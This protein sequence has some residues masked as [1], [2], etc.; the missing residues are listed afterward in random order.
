MITPLPMLLVIL[1]TVSHMAMGDKSM[2][3]YC[4]K[5]PNFGMGSY[6]KESNQCNVKYAIPTTNQ[7]EAQEFCEMQHPYSL[8]QVTH[9]KETWCYIMAELECGSSE[10]LIGENCFL[11]DADSKHSEGDD[12]CRAHGRT[13]KMHRITSVFEQKWLATF[14]SAYG[15]MWVKNAE[16]ENRHLLVTEVKDKIMINKEGRLAIGTSPNYVIVTRKGAVAGIKPGRLVRMNPNVEMPLLCSRPATPRK[17]YLKSIG[18][19]ME[20]IGYKITVARDLGDIDRPF[21]VIRGLH[22]FVMKDEY[23]AG[24]EDLYDSCSAFQHGYPATPYDFKNPEDFKKVLRE[25]E[26]NIVA[27]PGQKHTASQTP[28]MEKCTKDSDFERQRTHFYFNIKRKDGSFFEKGAANSSFWARQFPDRTCAD[29]PRVAMA[30][31]QRGLVDVPNNARLF[32]VCTF[33]APPNVKADEMSDDDCHPL[34]SYD[35]DLRQCKCKKDHEDLVDTKIFLK[36]ETDTQQ[37]G[38]HCLRCVATTEI[39]VFMIIDVF[40]GDEGRAGWA[41]AICLRFA[42]GFNNAWVR[43]LLLGG[44]GT[45]N[46]LDDTNTFHHVTMAIESDDTWYGINSK[47]WEGGKEH[48]GGNLLRAFE[49][50]F[51]ELDKRP[52]SRKLLV[53]LLWKPPKDIKDVVKRYNELLTGT[54]SVIEIFVASR[55]DELDRNLAKLSSSGTVY[56]VGLSYADSCRTS[57]RI[58]S[59]MQRLHCLR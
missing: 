58:A 4:L 28:N 40:D 46:I 17:E 50:G 20:Q 27:V 19:R 49:R 2:A 41:T 5:P 30:Y 15:M 31:T 24:P 45:D 18:D 1:L 54:D 23:S 7:A 51:T 36:R 3:V 32:V 13:Y 22:S 47:Y 26:V 10:V 39:D 8:K 42:F 38:I 52:A 53:L 56:K 6:N 25:A 33:G 37:R 21:T 16:L 35:K 34:A 11:F 57:T 14:F 48:R 12:R 59:I 9:G 44:G 29:M 43:S 55:H